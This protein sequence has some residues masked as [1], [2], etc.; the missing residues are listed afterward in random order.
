M[1]DIQ[2]RGIVS[3]PRETIIYSKQ[4]VT[5]SAFLLYA[6]KRTSRWQF[7]LLNPF[8]RSVEGSRT[9]KEKAWRRTV[10]DWWVLFDQFCED[11]QPEVQQK[12]EKV[13]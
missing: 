2:M 11:K 10:Q 4:E 6:G 5:L 9:Y 7:E 12:L 3:A 8:T 13:K 1:K